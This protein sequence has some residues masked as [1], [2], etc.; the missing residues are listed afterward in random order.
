M[1][2]L[3]LFLFI[4]QTPTRIVEKDA[5]ASPEASPVENFLS[6]RE[7]D[8]LLSSGGL[9]PRAFCFGYPATDAVEGQS[10]TKKEIPWFECG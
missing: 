3:R 9:R 1:G 10:E 5:A 4:V 7:K 6:P 2:L 8:M